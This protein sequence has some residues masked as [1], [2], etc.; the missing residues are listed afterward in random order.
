MPKDRKYLLDILENARLILTFVPESKD[1][2]ES[3]LLRQ[4]AVIRCLEIRGE[5]TKRLSAEFRIQH[6]DIAWKDMTG[7]RDIVTHEYHRIDFEEIWKVIQN[8][9]PALIAQIE[10]LIPPDDE[11]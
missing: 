4:Y 6:G 1:T 9:I 2:F 7:M 3:D 8:D 10:P 11:P 5:A